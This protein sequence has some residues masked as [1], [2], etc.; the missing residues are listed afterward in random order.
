MNRARTWI[1][2]VGAL[3]LPLLLLLG[4]ALFF[5]WPPAYADLPARP[6][7]NLNDLAVTGAAAVNTVSITPIR[8]GNA[9][10]ITVTVDTAT[11]FYL[12]QTPTGKTAMDSFFLLGAQLGADSKYTFTTDVDKGTAYVFKF[13][14]TCRITELIV[15]SVADGEL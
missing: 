13:G 14:T 2:V 1:A 8:P 12:T 7:L 15:K 10:R 3:L 4:P 6:V 5:G 11:T 9:W